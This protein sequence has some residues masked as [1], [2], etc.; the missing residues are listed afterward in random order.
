MYSIAW[1]HN[2]VIARVG[3]GVAVR[4]APPEAARGWAGLGSVSSHLTTHAHC[5]VEVVRA[6]GF[7]ATDRAQLP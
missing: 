5:P 2:G 3:R 1:S 4:P 7:P 6:G